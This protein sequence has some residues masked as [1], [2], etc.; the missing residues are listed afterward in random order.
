MRN[1]YSLINFGKLVNGGSNTNDPYA[2]MLP[3]TNQAAAINDFIQVRTNGENLVNS[4]Q[5]A[6]LP[7]SQGQHSPKSASEKKHEYE[8]KILSR[9]P[10]IFAG[11]LVFVLLLLGC[12]IWRCCKRRRLRRKA[13]QQK[14]D[15]SLS[16]SS[17]ATPSRKAGPYSQLYDSP[18]TTTL[19][20]HPMR[21]ST[22][23]FKAEYSKDAFARSP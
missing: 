19:P 5:Y 15:G 2:Q 17:P 12:C 8:E 11:C 21:A 13:A 20:M 9:W 14:Q 4:P 10:Y 23:E 22:L 3:L 7:A 1:A 18:S 16:T 6:L